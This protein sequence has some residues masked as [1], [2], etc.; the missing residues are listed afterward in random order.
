MSR[1][2]RLKSLSSGRRTYKMLTRRNSYLLLFGLLKGLELRNESKDLQCQDG[3]VLRISVERLLQKVSIKGKAS[4]TSPGCKITDLLQPSSRGEMIGSL[5][6]GPKGCS[7]FHSL[8]V[9]GKT[10]LDSSGN[11]IG[12]VK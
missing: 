10:P 2:P 12:P 8:A 3:L 7:F 9:S 4:N 6:T 1:S 11:R 5:L